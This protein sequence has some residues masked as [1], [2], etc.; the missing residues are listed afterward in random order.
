MPINTYITRQR[1]QQDMMR[2]LLKNMVRLFSL[3]FKSS[4]MIQNIKQF[5][6]YIIK[7]FEF[8]PTPKKQNS[9]WA[10]NYK[11]FTVQEVQ[12]LINNPGSSFYK[13]QDTEKDVSYILNKKIDIHP[14][15]IINNKE[16]LWDVNNDDFVLYTSKRL[17]LFDIINVFKSKYAGKNYKPQMPYE[18]SELIKSDIEPYAIIDK[19]FEVGSETFQFPKKI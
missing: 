11:P 14:V 6:Q 12:N 15:N 4:S 18:I 10:A 13:K 9:I 1:E 19:L 3:Q 5:H 2:I 16:F 17:L 8:I 7:Y